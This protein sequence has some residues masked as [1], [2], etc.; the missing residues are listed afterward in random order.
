MK[1]QINR[2]SFSFHSV[3]SEIFGLLERAAW[4][5]QNFADVEIVIRIKKLFAVVHWRGWRPWN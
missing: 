2:R 5:S 1:K 3:I 4:S